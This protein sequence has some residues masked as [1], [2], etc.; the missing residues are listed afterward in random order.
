MKNWPL[1][2]SFVLVLAG[3]PLLSW[4]NWTNIPAMWITG[5]VMLVVAA[6]FPAVGYRLGRGAERVGK[7]GSSR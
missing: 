4:G 6:L 7:S 1:G 5:L 2:V 3:F